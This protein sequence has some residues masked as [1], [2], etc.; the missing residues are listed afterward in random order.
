MSRCGPPSMLFIGPTPPP[1]QGVAV[2]TDCLLHSSLAE[3]F[4]IVHLDISDRRSMNNS[5]RLDF[6]N[7]YLALAHGVRFLFLTVRERPDIV[8]VPVSQNALGFLRDSLFLIPA[9]LLGGKLAIHLHGGAFHRFYGDANCLMRSLVRVAF[10]RVDLAIV[11]NEKYR[12]IFGELIAPGRVAVVENGIVD[13]FA[14]EFAGG[15]SAAA[16]RQRGLPGRRLRVLFLSILVESKGFVDVLHA[17]PQVLEQIPEA[18]FIFVGDGTGYA[19]FEKARAWIEE[20][21]LQTW[22]K[23]PGPKWGEE[24]RRILLDADVFAFPTWYPYEGQPRVVLEAMAAGLPIVTTQ[25][26]AIAE[27]VGEAG[28]LYVRPHDPADIAARLITLLKD[29]GLRAAMGEGNRRRFLERYTVDAFAGNLASAL[30]GALERPA[31]GLRAA[32]ASRLSS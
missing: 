2:T 17:V 7:V 10:S 1:H 22:V 15:F 28:A 31:A 21:G 25:H 20:R 6:G 23:F 19:E 11:L 13:E 3:S 30:R 18:E 4:R 8:Y 24:K 12:N 16:Q 29:R 14:A 27:T 9:K 26:A 32:R 5:E